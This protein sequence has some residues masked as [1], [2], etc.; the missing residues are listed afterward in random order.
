MYEVLSI[1]DTM[2]FCVPCRE[3]MEQHIITDQ[4]IE[5]VCQKIMKTYEQRISTLEQKI[6]EKCG[7][8]VVHE[9]EQK[10]ETKCGEEDV[11]D[12]VQAELS[13]SN[14]ATATIEKDTI[15]TL[16][17]EEISEKMTVNE[18]PINQKGE[19][20]PNNQSEQ[21]SVSN[22]I[23]EMRER[24]SREKNMIVFGIPEADTQEERE[25]YDNNQINQLFTDCGITLDPANIEKSI[26][27]GK[28]NAGRARPIKVS[29]Q[30]V[31]AKV[32]LFTNMYK[33]KKMA[34]Y[35]K[36]GVSNDLTKTERKEEKR[37]WEEAQRLQKNDGKPRKVRGPPSARRIVVIK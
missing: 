23:E 10:I 12:I 29:L 18:V 30:T 37:L 16:V 11:R 5:E 25:T 27:L 36:V 17:Q 22:L 34:K 15:R 35:E 9:L 20:K 24:K 33:A 21:P 32:S 28:Y 8:E 3:K 2:W 7:R 26:R 14:T 31:E 6:E 19:G 13:K 4:K 1:S